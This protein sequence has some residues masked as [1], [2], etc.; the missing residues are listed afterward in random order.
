MSYSKLVLLSLFVPAI[1]LVGCGGGDS[2]SAKS[3]TGGASFVGNENLVGNENSAPA[4]SENPT[5]TVDGEQETVVE[6]TPV[7]VAPAPVVVAPAPVVVEP[8]PVVVEPAPVVVEPT[9]V[10]DTTPALDSDLNVAE[11]DESLPV[12]DD[13]EPEI[14]D[15]LAAIELVDAESLTELLQIVDGAEVDLSELTQT[16]NFTVSLIE[17]ES[18]GSIAVKMTGCASL[19]RVE[20]QAPYTVGI[21]DIAFDTLEL[22]NCSIVAT[23]YELANATGEAGEPLSV[24]F[25]VVSR[26][27]SLPAIL[28]SVDAHYDLLL[29]WDAPVARADGSA[30]P[31]NDLTS[32]QIRSTSVLDGEE[33]VFSVRD[34]SATSYLLTDLAAGTYEFRIAAIDARGLSSG[35][36]EPLVVSV[37]E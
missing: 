8:A 14:L 30:L 4:L 5:S 7:V 3:D 33:N 19:D 27:K 36:S 35:F 25:S 32:Y 10:V 1:G 34:A 9:P 18:V 2:V 13:T 23:P 6:P 29:D 11:N 24:S 28:P 16:F 37:G 17:G 12:F 21:Q 15:E 26:E 22:G 31:V 20:N